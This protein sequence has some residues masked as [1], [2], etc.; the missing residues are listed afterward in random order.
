MS[1]PLKLALF[2]ITVGLVI[3]WVLVHAN[4]RDRWSDES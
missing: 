3:V 1:L 4:G 2:V